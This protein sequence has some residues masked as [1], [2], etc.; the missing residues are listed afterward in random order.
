MARNKKGT[1]KKQPRNGGSGG[2]EKPWMR[3]SQKA[4]S[5]AQIPQG[6]GTNNGAA[7]SRTSRRKKKN[8]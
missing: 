7:R 6:E 3:M 4:S 8:S 2:A 5:D 1:E